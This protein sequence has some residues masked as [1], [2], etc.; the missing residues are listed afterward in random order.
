VVKLSVLPAS[1][2]EPAGF[3]RLS[4]AGAEPGE[5]RRDAD[6]DAAE[7]APDQRH[8]RHRDEALVTLGDSG[9]KQSFDQ[10][11]E[12]VGRVKGGGV[13]HEQDMNIFLWAVQAICCRGSGSVQMSATDGE[14]A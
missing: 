3:T 5:Q 13:G 4:H 11:G 8:Q 6:A 9:R 1:G 2:E 7:P 10:K 12:A 14:R